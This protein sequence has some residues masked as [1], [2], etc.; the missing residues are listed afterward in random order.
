MDQIQ[1]IYFTNQ[2][3]VF[4]SSLWLASHGLVPMKEAHVTKRF[5][6]YRF[7]DPKHFKKLRTKKIGNGIYIIFGFN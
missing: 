2:W 4:R 6:R 3:S 7:V 5:I 1:S